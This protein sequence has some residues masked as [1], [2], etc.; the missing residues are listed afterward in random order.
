MIEI[1]VACT[2]SGIVSSLVTTIISRHRSAKPHKHKWTS[3]DGRH[4]HDIR[5]R[6]CKCSAIQRFV[7]STGEVT[8]WIPDGLDSGL[9][10]NGLARKAYEE[11]N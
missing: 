11:L 5:M 9:L 2:L 4:Y 3:W 7:K 6:S 10:D 1:V 8:I